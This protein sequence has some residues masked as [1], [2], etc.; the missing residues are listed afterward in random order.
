MFVAI[1]KECRKY[2]L[3]VSV[4]LCLLLFFICSAET[5]ASGL[6]ENE[7]RAT[8]KDSMQ[9]LLTGGA[10]GSG[11]KQNQKKLNNMLE[12][13]TL[14]KIKAKA[15]LQHETLC[16]L[17]QIETSR[18]ILKKLPKRVQ[19][20]FGPHLQWE[21][22]RKI[23]WRA[24]S[25]PAKKDNP[26]K[27]T[28]ATLAPPGTPWLNVPMAR[29]VPVL[30]ELTDNKIVIK[31]YGAGMKGEDTEIL[32]K[33]AAGRLDGCGCTALGALEIS[34]EVS[35]LLTPG[36][37]KNYE[38]VDYI[39]EKF[40]PRIAE[41]LRE[42]GYILAALI[43]TG[44][45]YI[46]TK[47][48]I[49]GLDDL[50]KQKMLTWV[51]SLEKA[52]YD[53]LGIEATAVDV[54]QVISALKTGKANACMAPPAWMLGM[55]AYQYTNYYIKSPWL[56]SPAIVMV[57]AETKDRLSRQAGVSE[58]FGQNVQELIIFELGQLEKA[59]RH[60]TRAYEK[61]SLEAFEK[62]AGMKPVTLPPGDRQIL[63][64]AAAGVREQLGGKAWPADFMCDVRQALAQYRKKKN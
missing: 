33:M 48:K 29:L 37:L 8:L 26:L 56:Y 21:E 44:W 23:L 54:P 60:S 40:R 62:K 24:A 50:R 59:W 27:I 43:D 53:E 57:N 3:F 25:T 46:F 49:S 11:L 39:L 42:N 28:I 4:A 12:K 41:G 7:I 18:H 61:R 38:E 64:K 51:G 2:R 5:M 52:L 35:A 63:K 36:L 30:K 34:P 31:I 45:F 22:I 13:G 6:N 16:L 32:Q 15:I 19:A 17:D 9:A 20:V 10:F 58:T 14:N 47:N 1:R 55:Q